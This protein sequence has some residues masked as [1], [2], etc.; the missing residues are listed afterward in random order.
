M[1]TS[2]IVIFAGMLLAIFLVGWKACKCLIDKK[3]AKLAKLLS[4]QGNE[5]SKVPKQVN[6]PRKLGMD[7]DALPA[8]SYDNNPP[9][10]YPVANIPATD[11]AG[12]PVLPPAASIA[13]FT[14]KGSCDITEPGFWPSIQKDYDKNVDPIIALSVPY[15]FRA[16]PMATPPPVPVPQPPVPQPTPA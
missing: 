6:Q 4:T 15:V 9:P 2:T 8:S 13:N 5:K 7:L 14:M 12:E 11:P 3:N 1:E 10:S 16:P